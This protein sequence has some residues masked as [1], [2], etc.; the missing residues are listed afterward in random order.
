MDV[1]IALGIP[2]SGEKKIT[3]PG[4]SGARNIMVNF[5][6]LG[7]GPDLQAKENK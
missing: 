3:D 4:L 1:F 7:E 2:T 6:S 5:C